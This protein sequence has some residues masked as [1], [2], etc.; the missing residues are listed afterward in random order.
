VK[1]ERRLTDCEWPKVRLDEC[2]EIVAGATPSTSVAAYWDGDVCWATP[3]DLS[4]LDGAHISDTPRKL[5]RTGL[6]SCAATIL[7]AGSVLFSSRAPIGH[8]AVNTVPMATNQG[9]KSFIPKSERL[10]AKFLY[11][12]LR[13]N[14]SYLESL[15][16][17][18]TFKEV[19]KA[20]V[21]RIQ[22]PL[23]PLA[24]QRRIAEVLD[25][26]EALRAKRRAA[27]AQLDSLTQSLF[28]ELHRDAATKS[29]TVPLSEVAEATRGSFVNGPFGSDLLTTELQDEGVPVIYIRDIRDGEYRRV[30]KSC[31]SERKAR[32][33]EVCSVR[34]GDVLVAKVGDPPGIAAVYPEGEPSGI[35]TQDVIR[36][37]V[38]QET[39]V[40]PFVVGYL[41]SSIGM[42]K[43]A[44]VTIE[45]TRARFS[46]KDF[47]GI[48]IELPP[49]EL[50]RE[51]A[52][53]VQAV[54]K[55]RTAQRASL[56]ELDALFASLQH[57]A[58]RGE[59]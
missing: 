48:N 13:T 46:L 45:A 38:S 21:S 11:W 36:I 47:K 19:S 14:R 28:L 25:R 53:R 20:I 1:A 31:V 39:A 4:E 10:N 3:K 8:V 42:W 34:P 44:G 41:N 55:L 24:E 52:R 49:I 58:F 23:P 7:P 9:F 22:I 15:G 29:H 43:V 16:N 30:S 56:A 12:W 59:L 18:A 40:S 33:L 35:V 5:T 2:T 37:R 27:L 57:R 17:G 51:F 32:N 54:E 50:Q 26:A 6:E